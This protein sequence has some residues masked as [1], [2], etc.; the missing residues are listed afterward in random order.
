MFALCFN[1]ILRMYGCCLISI[2][3]H[4][5]CIVLIYGLLAKDKGTLSIQFE[6]K[7]VGDFFSEWHIPHHQ[8]HH[9]QVAV[10]IDDVIIVSLFSEKNETK[11]LKS[12]RCY[13]SNERISLAQKNTFYI[14]KNPVVLKITSILTHTTQRE[15]CPY[16]NGVQ[17]AAGMQK[18]YSFVCHSQ[19]AI[20][21]SIQPMVT[22]N[23]WLSSKD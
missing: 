12:Y 2:V 8:H 6:L 22:T 9:T 11:Q 18:I 15:K 4:H 5:H 10:N 19:F 21:T 1:F 17:A 13:L 7:R 20:H 16:G 23:T 3:H 14:W